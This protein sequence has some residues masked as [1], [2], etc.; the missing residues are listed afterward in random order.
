MGRMIYY[1]SANAKI[2]GWGTKESPFKTIREAAG[3]PWP[4][5][6]LLWHREST[7]VCQPVNEVRIM[8]TGSSIALRSLWRR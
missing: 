5:T 3:L 1:V 6:K 8:T 2:N 4:G 7:G